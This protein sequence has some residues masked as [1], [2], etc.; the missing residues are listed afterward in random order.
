MESN[1]GYFRRQLILPVFKFLLIVV[2]CESLIMLV[3]HQLPAL[4]PWTVILDPLVLFTVAGGALYF[5]VTPVFGNSFQFSRKPLSAITSTAVDLRLFRQLME[6]T[7]DAVAIVDPQTSRL[8]DVNAAMTNL[9]GYSRSSLLKMTTMDIVQDHFPER[10]MET[11]MENLKTGG[12]KVLEMK[13]RCLDGSLLF[14]E[15]NLKYTELD[16]MDYLVMIGRDITTRKKKEKT[17]RE[18]ESRFRRLFDNTPLAYQSLDIEGDFIEVNTAWLEMFGYSRDEVIGHNYQEFIV[19]DGFVGRNLPRFLNAGEIGLPETP[20]CCKDGTVKYINVDGKIGYDEKKNFLQTHCILV[21]TSERLTAQEQQLRHELIVASS[22]DMMAFLD[23]DHTYLAVNPSYTRAFGLKREDLIGKTITDIFGK[24]FFENVIAPH[25]RSCL[26]SA[27]NV[28]YQAWFEF[29]GTGRK[30]MEI[31]YS[32]FIKESIVEGFVVNGRDIT[33]RKLMQ[34]ELAEHHL[35]LEYMVKERTAQLA[36]AQQ[37]AEAANN[38]KSTFLANMSHEIR[39]PM[40]AILG[41]THLVQQS[42]VTTEQTERLQKIETSS[43]H[44]LA[45]INNILDLSKIEA[46][47]VK[48]DSSDFYLE[49]IFENVCSIV[50]DQAALKA[51]NIDI[52]HNEVLS[53]LRGDQTQLCQALLNYLINAIKF[54]DEGSI[55]LSARKL[56]EDDGSVLVRFEVQDSGIG[57][58][59]DDLANLFRAFEQANSAASRKHGGTGLGLVITRRLAELMGGEAGAEST[60]G[61][62]STFWFTARLGHGREVVSV[63]PPVKS[64]NAGKELLD[65]YKKARILLAEDNA[66]NSE[67]A[68]ALLSSVGL[69]VDV[70]ENGREAVSMARNTAYDVILMDIQMPQMDGIEATRSIRSMKGL[71]ASDAQLPILAMTANIFSDDRDACMEAGMN[72]FVAKPV[73]PENLYA[74]LLKWLPEDIR[75]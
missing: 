68:T 50:K 29:P 31:A 60:P 13:V 30:F 66:I 8:I 33:K 38:A 62:G 70:A 32:P 58:A 15:V 7:G 55:L 14:A 56:E 10:E 75:T 35:H 25:S 9:L 23:R 12:F 4:G 48:L 73:D 59:P 67:V 74:V 53:C 46:G 49:E 21:D 69:T 19:E 37:M 51:L 71:I 1:T 43:K 5:L 45:I 2:V 61:Q 39:T 54:T 42:G 47:K 40:N 44:L 52:G 64:S 17:L 57:I 65:H 6:Q 16:G 24:E 36:D 3:L 11:L 22:S 26:S 18:S 20:M 63:K 41:L 72:D 34:D 27:K 28:T